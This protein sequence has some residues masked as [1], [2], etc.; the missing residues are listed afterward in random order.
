MNVG[1]L[2]FFGFDGFFVFLVGSLGVFED[3]D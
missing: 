1:V 2:C 3:V